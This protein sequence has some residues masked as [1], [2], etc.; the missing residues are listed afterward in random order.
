MSTDF[1]DWDP[2]DAFDREPPAP[3]QVAY[4]IH[5]I[6]IALDELA[7][8]DGITWNDLSATQRDLALAIGQAVVDYVIVADPD[9]PEDAAKSLHNVRRYLSG[10]TL[11]A[12]DDLPEP[13]RSVGIH[14]M[15]ILIAWLVRQGAIG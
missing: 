9:I 12:W 4:R 11:P 15:E 3:E 14:L 5:E 10:N 1:G 8:V 7:G 6:R 13:D 2:S